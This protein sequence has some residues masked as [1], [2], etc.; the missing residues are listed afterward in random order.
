VSH[1]GRSSLERLATVDGR[2]VEVCHAVIPHHD[3][4][5]IW[6]SRGELAQ[7]RAY[8]GG[9]SLK[10]WPNSK[11]NVAPPVL[12]PAVDIAPWYADAPHIR[13]D[14]PEEFIHLAGYMRQAA[15]VLGIPI[16]WGGDWDSDR[17]LHD[18]NKPFDLGHFELA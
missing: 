8:D 5:I 4:T 18:R 11:H 14:C 13:W 12:S 9:F 16:I 3:F 1:F 17:D 2:L 15:G 6:G 7:N 10:R